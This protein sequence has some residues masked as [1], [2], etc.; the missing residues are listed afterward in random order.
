MV[1]EL[2]HEITKLGTLRLYNNWQQFLMDKAEAWYNQAQI[3][4]K[5]LYRKVPAA[6][7][8]GSVE[9]NAPAFRTM[10]NGTR[11]KVYINSIGDLPRAKVIVSLSKSSPTKRM[12]RR[13]ELFDTTKMLSAHPELFKNEIRILTNDL[14]TTIE[15]EP[16]EQVK[17]ERMQ[18]LQE[19]RDILEVF[20]Q[21]EQLKAQ[22][23]EAQ[24]MQGRLQGMLQNLQGGMEQMAGQPQPNEQFERANQRL[25]A[26]QNP[27]PSGG[28]MI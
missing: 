21:I 7:G 15:R 5:N 8:V 26:P 9:F 19:M 4:Y 12:A 11:E 16:E 6:N 25:P 20:A 2:R 22:G 10:K 3:T 28:G 27:T 24:V 1:L 17:L 13:L 18:T 23:M 14:L